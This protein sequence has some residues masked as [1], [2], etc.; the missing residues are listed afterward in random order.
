MKNPA[1]LVLSFFALF[2]VSAISAQTQGAWA[3]ATNMNTPRNGQFQVP[4]GTGAL[5]AGGV[6]G[7]TSLTSTE[8]Y[9]TTTGKWT[10]TGNLAQFRVYSTAVAFK[11]AKVLVVGGFGISALVATAELYNPTTKKWSS[12]GSLASGR[13][14]NTATLLPNGQVLVAGGCVTTDCLTVTAD[15]ELYD[16]VKNT[17]TPTGSLATARSGHTALLLAN[18]KVLAVGGRNGVTLSTCELFD[19][20]TGIWSSAPSTIY[21]RFSQ[22]MSLLKSGKVLVTG[23]NPSPRFATSTAEIYDPV[24]NTWTVTSNLTQ[25]RL[26][27][28]A[29]LLSDGTTLITGGESFRGCGRN[30]CSYPLSS[31]EIYNE[32]SG[33]FT[34]TGSLTTPRALLVAT[35]LQSG[36]VLVGSGG[37]G[38]GIELY[39]PLTLAISAS[40]LSFGFEQIGLTTPAQTV[41]VTNVNNYSVKFTSIASS[42]DFAQTNNCPATLTAGQGC[43]LN[44]TFSPTTAGALSGSITLKDNSIGSPQQTISLAGT[45][46]AGALALN[47]TSLNFGNVTVG[48]SS[49]PLSAIMINDGAA[50]VNLTGIAIS[51]ADGIF[52][53]SN[54]CP[55]TLAVQQSCTFQVTFTPPDVFPYAETLMVTNSANGPAMLPLSGMGADGGLPRKR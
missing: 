43:V 37:P 44:V 41:T 30:F 53:Q 19:P 24:A 1:L 38:L 28:T 34:P 52:S 31:A 17:W 42:G 50:P 22:T 29:T 26:A 40:S 55:A 20:A 11:N 47:P 51:P 15:S 5:A 6:S 54:N 9:S 23:G 4:L 39:T 2:G 13:Y 48:L 32:T 10:T 16:P 8:T 21:P 14:Q 33:K 35:L 18:G 36:Q 12:A 45:G 27:H 49:L 7:N 46:S 3:T 25:P